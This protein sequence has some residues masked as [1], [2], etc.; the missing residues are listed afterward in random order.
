[1]ALSLA[2]SSYEMFSTLDDEDDLN[3]VRAYASAMFT[4][5]ITNRTM[6]RS[7]TQTLNAI[8][9]PGGSR[10]QRAFNQLMVNLTPFSSLTRASQKT[11]DPWAR[12]TDTLL[13]TFK[14]HYGLDAPRRYDILGDPIMDQQTVG[15][16]WFSPFNISRDKHNV[17]HD[18]VNRL[19]E[20]GF[21]TLAMPDRSLVKDGVSIK[22]SGQQ[23]QDYIYHRARETYVDGRNFVETLNDTLQNEVYKSSNNEEK[24]RIFDRINRKFTAESKPGFLRKHPEAQRM[25]EKLATRK[26]N[27][28]NGN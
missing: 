9:D 23:Y 16:P 11:Y 10:G 24:K 14:A 26:E 18:E 17:I 3:A 13:N 28:A 1:M 5:T 2:A 4:Q 8:M 25:L 15:S 27:R 22:M 20:A 6:L 7:L 21:R 19:T 12:E